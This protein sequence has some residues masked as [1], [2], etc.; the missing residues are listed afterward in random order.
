MI[1]PDLSILKIQVL[2]G[3]AAEFADPHPR[4][5]KNV[6]L[7]PITAKVIV[8]RNEVHE[9]LLLLGR[10]GNALFRIV[11]DH[12]QPGVKG[13]LADDVLRIGHL[14]RRFEN[15]PDAGN[16]SVGVPFIVEMDDEQLAVRDAE[17]SDFLLAEGLL[18]HEFQHIFVSNPGVVA[19]APFQGD[20]PLQKLN[21]RRVPGTVMDTV[22]AH[23]GD[24]I[25]LLP[26]FLQRLGVDAAPLFVQVGE[27]ILIGL[28]WLFVLSG[29][30]NSSFAVF[31][32]A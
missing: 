4:T 14:E 7:V 11:R 2:H 13:I 5:Q 28:V 21:H 18:F 32:S 10:H 3:Q 23:P 8:L 19:H 31:A 22:P 25:F 15:A 16:G 30:Q 1:H 12:V 17:I 9:Q 26:Q 27:P 20:V 6:D 24:L 29:P